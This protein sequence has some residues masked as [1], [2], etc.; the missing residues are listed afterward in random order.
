[1]AEY[2]IADRGGIEL[3]AQA[4]TALDR[5]E[6]LAAR[7]AQDGEI[8]VVKGVPHAHP[9]IREE[10]AARAFDCRTLQRLGLNIEPVKPAGRPAGVGGWRGGD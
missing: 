10:L 8:L 7:I 3:L 5:A 1:M 4:C 2:Q 9:C 6:A